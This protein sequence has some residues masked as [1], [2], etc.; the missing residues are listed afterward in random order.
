MDLYGEFRIGGVSSPI[1]PDVGSKLI[2]DDVATLVYECYT[3]I[4]LMGRGVLESLPESD[5][6]VTLNIIFAA[7]IAPCELRGYWKLSVKCFISF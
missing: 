2:I 3:Q 4:A 7:G 6:Q 5:G 1:S